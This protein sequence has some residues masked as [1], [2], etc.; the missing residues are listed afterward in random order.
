MCNGQHV[1]LVSWLAGNLP[2]S[3]DIDLSTELKL[4]FKPVGE[5]QS[6]TTRL[7]GSFTEVDNIINCFFTMNVFH[8]GLVWKTWS[9]IILWGWEKIMCVSE[10]WK[11]TGEVEI[12]SHS[13]WT[14]EVAPC[15]EGCYW[16]QCKCHLLFSYVSSMR[17]LCEWMICS[18]FGIRIDQVVYH[19]FPSHVVFS[20]LT[21]FKLAKQ[22]S[23]LMWLI[24]CLG[25]YHHLYYIAGNMVWLVLVIVFI[26]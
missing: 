5:A 18:T 19:T 23:F 16:R 22:C 26:A 21:A 6:E 14:R 3:L 25:F 24:F 2:P 10:R 17:I 9:E 15:C 13:S 20:L 7:R 1:L 12:G 8:F 4:S 11:G